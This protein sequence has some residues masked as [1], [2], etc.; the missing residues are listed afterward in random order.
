MGVLPA[1][2]PICSRLFNVGDNAFLIGPPGYFADASRI[3]FRKRCTDKNM[4]L[5]LRR[6]FKLCC[7]SV[8]ICAIS[9]VANNCKV[10]TGVFT[11][12]AT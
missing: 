8:E 10:S 2:E 1:S 11:F 7:A 12:F 3:I 4:L 5:S 6:E 9:S